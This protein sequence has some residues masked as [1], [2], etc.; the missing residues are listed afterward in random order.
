MKT[1]A[2]FQK[3]LDAS[4]TFSI[5]KSADLVIAAQT[6]PLKP[7][8]VSLKQWNGVEGKTGR[9]ELTTSVLSFLELSALL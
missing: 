1:V 4:R 5:T 6:G 2:L 9:S 7:C 8:E 3:R